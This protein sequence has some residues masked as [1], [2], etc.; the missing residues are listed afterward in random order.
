MGATVS[1]EMR[2]SDLQR[3][4]DRAAAECAETLAEFR[5]CASAWRDAI[6]RYNA[7]CEALRA[8]EAALAAAPPDPAP[9]PVPEPVVTVDAESDRAASSPGTK[10]KR[11]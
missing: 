8:A 9:P 5:R 11:R 7:A 6:A 1:T 10:R 4:V 2:R 3:A